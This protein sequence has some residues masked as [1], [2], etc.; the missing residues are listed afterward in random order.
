MSDAV[1]MPE[2]GPVVDAKLVVDCIK[3]IEC[4]V[5][6][7]EPLILGVTSGTLSTSVNDVS[8]SGKRKSVQGLFGLEENIVLVNVIV[9]LTKLIILNQTPEGQVAI[10]N[11]HL[12]GRSSVV[13]QY[14]WVKS[15]EYTAPKLVMNID[16]IHLIEIHQG[17]CVQN[18]DKY[19]CDVD[20]TLVSKELT[21]DVIG[22]IRRL[23]EHMKK[24]PGEN[25][26]LSSGLAKEDGRN[27]KVDYD[28]MISNCL[29]KNQWMV[30]GILTTIWGSLI[31]R[32]RNE[33]VRLGIIAEGILIIRSSSLTKILSKGTANGVSVI[34][35][36]RILFGF[37]KLYKNKISEVA[38]YYSTSYKRVRTLLLRITNEDNFNKFITSLNHRL[39]IPQTNPKFLEHMTTIWSHGR[40]STYHY[41]GFLNTLGGRSTKDFTVYPVYPW[42]LCESFQY[43]R[44]LADIEELRDLSRPIGAIETSRLNELLMKSKILDKDEYYLYGSH[45]SNASYVSFWLLR[46]HYEV[47]MMINEGRLD[48]QQRSFSDMRQAWERVKREPNSFLELLPEMYGNS[49]RFLKKVTFATDLRQGGGDAVPDVNV[50]CVTPFT[51]CLCT[52]LFMKSC[53]CRPEFLNNDA[54]WFLFC[55]RLILES[56]PVSAAVHHWIDLIFGY[57]QKGE[58]A[59]REHNLFHPAS[60]SASNFKTD[61]LVP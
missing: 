33:L 35:Y 21:D 57:K 52:D 42:T 53:N 45:Y 29:L 4:C 61:L 11:G 15:L 22:L 46:E 16:H 12:S 19:S 48:Y 3:G 40:M 34:H 6:Y 10:R 41:L 51:K 28:K 31:D 25:G 44:Q 14:R 30:N 50:H 13:V 39:F 60:Y 56:P 43:P 54:L 9:T 47:N 55:H 27:E 32:M 23:I 1:P 26:A 18:S 5:S 37:R 49:C 58:A 38:I 20:I 24:E 17:R 59:R 8:S 7:D 2:A 36:N